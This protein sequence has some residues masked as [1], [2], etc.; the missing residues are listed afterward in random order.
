VVGSLLK[1]VERTDEKRK[2]SAKVRG[3]SRDGWTKRELLPPPCEKE[4]RKEL[5]VRE[6]LC[7]DVDGKTWT[8]NR[9][10]RKETHS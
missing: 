1:Q 2:Q 5:H 3:R 4:G 9:I 8:L 7:E 10:A 6:P